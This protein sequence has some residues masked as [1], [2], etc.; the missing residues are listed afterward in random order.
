MWKALK[1]MF[2]EKD[3]VHCDK[4]V[5]MWPQYTSTL[6]TGLVIVA[7]PL[8]GTIH[9]IHHGSVPLSYVEGGS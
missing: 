6:P 2:C 9:C 7:S 5:I 4:I 8:F 1:L 3:C